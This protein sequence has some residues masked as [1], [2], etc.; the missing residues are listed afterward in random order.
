MTIELDA[1]PFVKRTEFFPGDHTSEQ[2]SHPRKGRVPWE[3]P[4]TRGRDGV[5]AKVKRE[6]ELV[7][8]GGT[9]ALGL[10]LPR[11]VRPA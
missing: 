11:G 8:A 6:V 4:G 5:P 3:E 2:V 10:A 1:L 9:H 7:R